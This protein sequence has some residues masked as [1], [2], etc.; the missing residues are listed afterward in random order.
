MN[1]ASG[2]CSFSWGRCF[3]TEALNSSSSIVR[4]SFGIEPSSATSPGSV[5]ISSRKV[6]MAGR[7]S[8]IQPF[9]S[10][11]K[12]SF[13]PNSTR[14]ARFCTLLQ[15][16]VNALAA[17]LLGFSPMREK[18]RGLRRV[19]PKKR[20]KRNPLTAVKRTMEICSAEYFSST[21][22]RMWAKAALI[23]GGQRSADSKIRSVTAWAVSRR[24]RRF[25][26]TSS[27]FS[28][29]RGSTSADFVFI[30]SLVSTRMG[31]RTSARYS[32]PVSR[33]NA[34]IAF[35]TRVLPRKMMSGLSVCWI[36]WLVSRFTS[37]SGQSSASKI[38]TSV[39]PSGPLSAFVMSIARTSFEPSSERRKSAKS[40]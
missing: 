15:R 10:F 12:G 20:R 6:F 31:E 39:M 13:S 11:M 35:V 4:S 1:E 22:R 8:R 33:M 34:S 26:A 3:S 9:M 17:L 36:S 29:L 32:G 14:L 2:F 21:S 38:F 19:G 27:P 30:F 40:L 23:M 7:L 24:T 25:L 37:R 16:R 5:Q 28:A 18:R